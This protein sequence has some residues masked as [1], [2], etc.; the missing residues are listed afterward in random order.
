VR[1]S[2]ST[3]QVVATAPKAAAVTIRAP[4]KATAAPSA[5]VATAK[6]SLAKTEEKPKAPVV[7]AKASV[8]KVTPPKDNSQ[9]KGS[10]L[11]Q[12]EDKQSPSTIILD[13]KDEKD[14]ELFNKADVQDENWL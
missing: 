8:A 9:D 7:V 12:R 11:I 5:P 13:Q 2:I 6:P 1:K 3:A 10:V 14:T 4:A